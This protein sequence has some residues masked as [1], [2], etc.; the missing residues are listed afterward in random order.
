MDR[1]RVVS[2]QLLIVDAIRCALVRRY[3][4]GIGSLTFMIDSILMDYPHSPAP[5]DNGHP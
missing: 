3:R 5:G 4:F 2:S 1:P